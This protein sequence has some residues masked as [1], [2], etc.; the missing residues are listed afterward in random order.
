MILICFLVLNLL[1]FHEI[2]TKCYGFADTDP[3]Q[4]F[5][6]KLIAR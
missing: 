5:H 4:L 6:D 2:I 3:S 1:L